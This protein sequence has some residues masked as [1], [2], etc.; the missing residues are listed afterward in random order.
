M[1]KIK[2]GIFG[3][4]WGTILIVGGLVGSAAAWHFHPP[5]RRAVCNVGFM[6]K[7]FPLCK[8]EPGYVANE[9]DLNP[10]NM[11]GNITPGLSDEIAQALGQSDPATTARLRA[12][13]IA[14]RNPLS[15]GKGWAKGRFKQRFPKLKSAR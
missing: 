12:Y 11:R 2:K 8:S 3:F 6:G 13:A 4:G 14:D 1:G 9:N 10:E 15:P 5:F 7:H